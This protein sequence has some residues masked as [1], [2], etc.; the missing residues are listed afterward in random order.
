MK[1]L[2]KYWLLV[3]MGLLVSACDMESMFLKDIDVLG[4]SEIVVVGYISPD[5]ETVK[6]AVMKAQT[7]GEPTLTNVYIDDAEVMISDG[8]NEYSM[9]W[10]Q[11]VT[12]EEIED[13][14]YY[15]YYLH[16]PYFV[17][18]VSNDVV[19]VTEGKTY[20]LT[21]KAEGKALRA[22][23]TVPT[24]KVAPEVE[25]SDDSDSPFLNV[26]WVKNASETGFYVVDAQIY[27]ETDSFQY[28]D[29]FT[30]DTIS[31]TYSQR[32]YLYDNYVQSSL[33]GQVRF[34]QEV[35]FQNE[36]NQN[37]DLIVYVVHADENYFRY[38][39]SIEDA[40]YQD[41]NPFAEPIIIHSNIENGA[42]CFGAY[43]I[44]QTRLPFD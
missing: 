27:N 17:Y 41:G 22:S 14:E 15:Y 34:R 16:D 19:Q 31:E 23:C 39:K 37:T 36:P 25:L 42:G 26:S 2:K 8:E 40:S 3:C 18:E 7:I 43:V 9:T 38:H 1:T 35:Y 10:T 13:D 4:E 24:G 20:H 33:S 30:G 5:D 12:D 32:L 6:V 11:N 21:V 29:F 28:T 44:S